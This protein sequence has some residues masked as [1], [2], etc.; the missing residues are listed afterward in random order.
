LRDREKFAG[1]GQDAASVDAVGV[2]LLGPR[3]G[4][5]GEPSD[6]GQ[7]LLRRGLGKIDAHFLDQQGALGIVHRARQGR[8]WKTPFGNPA[9]FAAR[10]ALSAA[11]RQIDAVETG[12]PPGRGGGIAG[13]VGPR[14][15]MDAVGIDERVE[16]TGA[17]ERQ[18]RGQADH[19]LLLVVVERLAIGSRDQA[20]RDDRR[21]PI[22]AGVVADL[23]ERGEDLQVLAKALGDLNTLGVVRQ[24]RETEDFAL[25]GQWK[26]RIERRPVDLVAELDSGQNDTVGSNWSNKDWNDALERAG[27]A[28]DKGGPPHM[29]GKAAG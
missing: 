15:G 21:R 10:G 24:I 5:P 17:Q 12:G 11:L 19:V 25:T 22:E 23:L 13:V 20:G 3:I 6:P 29:A 28:W 4:V 2:H 7:A 26:L 14:V 8:V 9:R 27:S 16:T 18:R 1:L